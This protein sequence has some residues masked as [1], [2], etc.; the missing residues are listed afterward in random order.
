[1][2]SGRRCPPWLCFRALELNPPKKPSLRSLSRRKRDPTDCTVGQCGIA[3]DSSVV[4]FIGVTSRGLHRSIGD[5][6]VR[7][8][9]TYLELPEH[10]DLRRL[11]QLHL[12]RGH[13]PLVWRLSCRGLAFGFVLTAAEIRDLGTTAL[14]IFLI[15]F[16]SELVIFAGP[17]HC[18][19][20]VRYQR[21]KY[22][23]RAIFWKLKRA[24]CWGIFTV[25][26]ER[27]RLRRLRVLCGDR[28]VH[29]QV[30]EPTAQA[31]RLK[32][33]CDQRSG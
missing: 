23:R 24:R 30:K 29:S 4:R 12:G 25:V 27:R 13:S 1:M 33:P 21:F 3:F 2:Y 19:S 22:Y 15:H 28:Q 8:I 9:G 14:D 26:A 32:H 31:E 5:F 20:I 11:Q 17:E 18:R 6:R 7:F 16:A 10:R